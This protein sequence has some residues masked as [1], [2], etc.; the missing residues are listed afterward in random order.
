MALVAM[1]IANLGHKARS[2]TGSPGR[3]DHRLARTARPR[4]STSRPGRIENALDD[5]AHRDRGRLPGRL[6]RTPRTSPRS[7]AAAPTPPRSRWPPRSAPRSAR[8]TPTST[9]SSP[10]TRGS[11]R[12]PASSTGSPPRRCSRWRP[13]APRSCTCGASST[14]AATTCPIHVR[15]SFSQKE[16]TWIVPDTSRREHDG[17]GD[18]RRRRPRPQRGQDH[19]RRRARQGRR[20]GP[21]LRG[22]RRR[23]GQHRHG[24]AERLGGRDRPHRHLLHAAA[25]RRPDRDG[26]AG[27]DPGRGRLRLAALRRPDRQGLADR[28][29]HALAPR[30]HREVLRRARL[31]RASTSR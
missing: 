4:S 6:A 31:G 21:D 15:S 24:R 29:R 30:H 27:P 10:P 12:P 9:A 20:G 22:A 3:R 8:S 7:A 26:G 28:R 5:G 11:S 18:H 17:T 1:A 13:A 14:P 19:R 16:G 2:F 25:R 23:R